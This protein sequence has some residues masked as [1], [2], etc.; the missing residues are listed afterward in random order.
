ML[1]KALVAPLFTFDKEHYEGRHLQAVDV[2]GGHRGSVYRKNLDADDE[3]F[4]FERRG[5]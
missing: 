4:A 5:S 3:G 1:A 2:L